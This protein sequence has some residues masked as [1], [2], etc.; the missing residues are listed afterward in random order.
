MSSYIQTAKQPVKPV[1][2]RVRNVIYAKYNLYVEQGLVILTLGN[3]KFRDSFVCKGNAKTRTRSWISISTACVCP[4][5]SA[6]IVRQIILFWLSMN[7]IREYTVVDPVYILLLFNQ[8][9]SF[10]KVLVNVV[11]LLNFSVLPF[12]NTISVEC[13]NPFI[14][15][16]NVGSNSCH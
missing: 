11:I 7:L 5:V 14:E 16:H 3:I 9:L 13:K 10:R 1:S 6:F 4:S 8:P 2:V 12:C 15:L